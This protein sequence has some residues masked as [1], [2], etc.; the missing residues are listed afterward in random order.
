[1]GKEVLMKAKDVIQKY[2]LLG[3]WETKV[4]VDCYHVLIEIDTDYGKGLVCP[5]DMCLNETIYRK[6]IK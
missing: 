2:V 3:D 5:N 1:M 4:C 6:E